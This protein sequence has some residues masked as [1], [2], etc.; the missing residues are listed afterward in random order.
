MRTGLR[1]GIAL[2]STSSTSRYGY[3][4]VIFAEQYGKIYAYNINII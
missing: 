2:M 4:N 3:I 1:L